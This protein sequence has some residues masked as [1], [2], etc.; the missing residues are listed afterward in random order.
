M[1]P[2]RFFGP[3][4]LADRGRRS[5]IVLAALTL[6]VSAGGA[7]ADSGPVVGWGSGDFRPPPA[8][9][10]TAGTGSAIAAGYTHSCAIQAGTGAVVCWGSIEYGDI[11]PPSAVDGTEGTAF[12]IAASTWH[13]CA[14][15]AGTGAVVCWGVDFGFTPPPAVDGTAGSASAISVGGDDC[16]DFCVTEASCA[17]QAGT[18]AVVCWGGPAPPPPSVNGTE[19]SALAISVGRGGLHACAIQAGTNAV[20]CWGSNYWGA[21][22][23]PPS[24]DGTTGTATAIAAG[25]SFTLAIAAPEPD[26]VPLGLASVAMLVAIAQR[27]RLDGIDNDGDGPDRLRRRRVGEPRSSAR[28]A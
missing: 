3:G 18:G 23:P 8:V 6:A 20:V 22:T 16:G 25:N 24:V 11:T 4:A 5:A 10:G 17:I 15:Q 7:G 27:R 13:S 2:P 1:T 9:D 14:I 21:A 28:A 12:A 19:G 26:V